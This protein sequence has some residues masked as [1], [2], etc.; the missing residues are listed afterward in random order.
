MRVI[1]FFSKCSKLDVDVKYAAKKWEK[2]FSFLDNCSWIG[3]GKFF[4]L[5]TEYLSLA[6]DVLTNAIKILD[7]ERRTF[8]NSIFVKMMKQFD[9]IAAVQ[10]LGV[11]NMLAVEGCSET[12]I[13]RH[14]TNDVFCS[15]K[16]QKYI[17]YESRLFFNMF[18]IWCRFQISSQKLRKFFLFLS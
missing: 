2:L 13:F 14:S 18:K 10:F 7:T 4:L 15:L 11:F 5:Q 16:F 8:S 6:F 3:S 12:E 9:E 17:T 1:F